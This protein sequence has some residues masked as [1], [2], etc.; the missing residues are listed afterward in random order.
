MEQNTK[1]WEEW[2]MQ[3]IGGSDVA[4][5]LKVSPYKTPFQLWEEKLGLV[6]QSDNNNF[7]FQKGHRLEPK[8]RAMYEIQSDLSAKP[9]L[10]MRSDMPHHRASLDGRDKQKKIIAEFK[11]VGA[12][13]KWKLALEGRLPAEYYAQCQWQLWVTGDNYVNYV[14]YNEKENKIKIIKVTPDLDYIKNMVTE[15]NLFWDLVQNKKEPELIDQ[16]WKKIRSTELKEMIN[17][18][19]ELAPQVKRFDTLKKAIKDHKSLNHARCEAYGVKIYEKTRAGSVDWKTIV[20]DNL[21]DI[22]TS[23]YQKASTKYKEI[24]L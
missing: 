16:D 11:F 6:N 14:P 10:V 2:R 21:P 22:D 8:I 13:D 19:K 23:K 20:K 17:E 18:L 24:K 9:E 15:V 1:K 12:G 3:G 5:I 4:S 7:I